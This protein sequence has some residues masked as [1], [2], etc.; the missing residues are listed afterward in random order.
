MSAGLRYAI[1]L[2]AGRMRPKRRPHP[3]VQ[4]PQP[5]QPGVSVIVPS[6]N[7]KDLLDALLPGVTVDLAKIAGEIIVVDNGSD[8]GTVQWL[9]T[10]WPTVR[11]EHSPEPLSFARAVNRGVAA[12][13]FSHVCMLNNDMLVDRGF[14]G[15]LG[16]AFDAVP[17]LFCATAQI[18]FPPGVRREETGKAVMAH[19]SPADFPL[20]C[21]EPLPGEDMTWVLYG[22]GGCSVYDAAKLRALGGVDEIYEPAYVEDLDLG[23]RAW[24]K[25]WPSVYVAGAQVEHRHRA[26][27]SRYY[28]A[29]QLDTILEIN[30]LTFLARAVAHPKLFRRL[31]KEALQ[32]LKLLAPE[33]AS[34]RAA[35]AKAPDIATSGGPSDTAIQSEQAFLDLTNGSVAVFRGHPPTGKPVTLVATPRLAG[36]NGRRAV[37]SF[38]QV[39]VA[40]V[41]RL[42][43]PSPEIL[44]VCTEVV[45]VRRPPAGV[46][47]AAFATALRLSTRKWRPRE[48]R[49]ESKSMQY[50]MADCAPAKIISSR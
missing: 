34:A 46:E 38:D 21:D 28:T 7:G 1:A 33:H 48:A 29:E 47:S 12:A 9:A 18:R 42:E 6:R 50:Y 19:D 11:V 27:T 49:L 14:F 30:Y 43:P 32:R 15:A 24:Q 44:A 22:S 39:V 2:A 20:R 31:W 17:D 36:S 40:Q 25:G 35:L 37:P 3:P 10:R 41:D 23:Y 4:P 13:R 16:A 26:T 8:D 5:S 45:L